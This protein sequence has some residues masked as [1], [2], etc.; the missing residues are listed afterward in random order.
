[1]YDIVLSWCRSMIKKCI[2][3]QSIK[4]IHIFVTVGGGGGK[5]HLIRTIYPTA[6][7]TFKYLPV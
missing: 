7:N 6:V 5:S 2:D 4:L 3:K 1:M